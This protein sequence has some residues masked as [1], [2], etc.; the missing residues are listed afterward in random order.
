M[1]TK[2]IHERASRKRR[3]Y[4]HIAWEG[5]CRRCG[6]KKFIFGCDIRRNY[7]D[8]Y[9]DMRDVEEVRCISSECVGTIKIKNKLPPLRALHLIDISKR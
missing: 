1:S 7:G 4:D 2:K 9:K 5:I 3:R 6:V 8:G